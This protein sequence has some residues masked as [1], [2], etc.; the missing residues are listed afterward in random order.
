M[1]GAI[2]GDIIGSV[3]KTAGIKTKLFLPFS[4]ASSVTIDS[5]M[6]V[7]TARAL[8]TWNKDLESLHEAMIR[9][10]RR[11]GWKYLRTNDEIDSKFKKWLSSYEPEPYNSYDNGS[12]LR[13]TPCGLVATSMEEA[14]LLAKIATEVTHASAEAITGTQAV[15]AAIYLTKVGNSKEE[16]RQYIGQNFYALDLSLA[17]IRPNYR[18]NDTCEGSVPQAIVAFLESRNYEDAIRN[19]VSL[20]GD[21]PTMAAIAGSIAWSYYKFRNDGKMTADMDRLDGQTG[22]R[23]PADFYEISDGFRWRC[24]QIENGVCKTFIE[25]LQNQ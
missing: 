24:W 25:S 15:A 4:K 10:M 8:V 7:A 1:R 12:A 5:I 23:I 20:G 22:R 11:V 9:N 2:L 19:A 18:F 17:E 21:A 16:I 13:G 14:L 3:Y 6:M